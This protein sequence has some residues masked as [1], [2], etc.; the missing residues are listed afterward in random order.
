MRC[1]MKTFKKIWFYIFMGLKGIFFIPY[2]IV[3]Y[4]VRGFQALS[5]FLSRG[6]YFYFSK[7][8]E[9]LKK[10]LP[11][12]FFDKV[13]QFFQMRQEQPSHIVMIIVWFLA[14]LYLFDTFYVSPIETTQLVFEDIPIVEQVALEDATTSVLN[15]NILFSKEMNLYRIYGKYSMNDINFADL[16]DKNSQT[17]AWLMVE[18]TSINYP[19]VQTDNNDYYLNHSYDYSYSINGWTFMD[20]RNNN[21][22][23]D[24]NTVFYG[25][26]LLNKTSF[27]SLDNIFNNPERETKIRVI[28]SD[29]VVYTYQ[30]F[31]AYFI[32]PEIY[33]LQTSFYGVSDYQEFLNVISSR[34]VLNVD[35]YVTVNDKVITLSTCTDDNK[36]RKVVHARLVSSESF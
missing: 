15:D 17:V 4:F 29:R 26:N 19:I 10:I 6:F 2:K 13:I 7:F 1:N 9:L 27:G 8:F 12:S 16:K 5:L 20:Y 31:S 28:T 36:G 25:H 11:I 32:E 21:K 33:Y 34:S 35:N 14:G 3:C 18:G 24:A 23:T 30:V 22:M